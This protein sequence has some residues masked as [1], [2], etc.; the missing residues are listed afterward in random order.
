MSSFAEPA[1][2]VPNVPLF[3]CHPP[4]PTP[5]AAD[6]SRSASADRS[7]PKFFAVLDADFQ[8]EADEA[9]PFEERVLLFHSN[10]PIDLP[11]KESLC[12]LAF[13]FVQAAESL[14]IPP[15][16]V[17]RLR[18]SKMVLL[19]V[20]AST[21]LVRKST[22]PPLTP[23]VMSGSVSDDEV[24]L[25]E[26]VKLFAAALFVFA[27]NLTAMREVGVRGGGLIGQ[28]CE[29]RRR[30]AESVNSCFKMF[31]ALTNPPPPSALAIVGA[32]P[33]LSNDAV[34]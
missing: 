34:R 19:R 6:T 13:F 17:V 20:D 5:H 28:R 2:P 29:T 16:D 12:G 15:P 32:V 27:G 10:D 8:S 14:K 21:V 18:R 23:Q 4:P 11:M 30:Y 1:S 24:A 33:H 26:A 25:R 3:L 7:L 31:R 22:P 9:A